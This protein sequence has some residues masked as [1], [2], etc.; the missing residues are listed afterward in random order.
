M[1][2]GEE[3]EHL[4]EGEIITVIEVMDEVQVISEEMVFEVELVVI[5]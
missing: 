2:T 3:R 1:I 4:V 5:L